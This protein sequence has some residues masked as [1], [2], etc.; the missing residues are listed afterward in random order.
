MKIYLCNRPNACCP[1]VELLADGNTIE[2]EDDNGD[3]V[4]M[5][6]SEFEELKKIELKDL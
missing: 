3:T 4:Q 6:K 2:I 1:S 5:T